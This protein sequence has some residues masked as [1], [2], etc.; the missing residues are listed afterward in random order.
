MEDCS[1]HH[2]CVCIWETTSN[3]KKIIVFQDLWIHVL[4][5]LKWETEDWEILTQLFLTAPNSKWWMEDF[6]F[7]EASSLLYI[8]RESTVTFWWVNSCQHNKYGNINITASGAVDSISV[9]SCTF[10]QMLKADL[11]LLIIFICI[12]FSLIYSK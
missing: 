4:S 1:V 9:W 10:F 6:Y 3:K 7:D 8:A 11:Y 5:F 12:L 2:A